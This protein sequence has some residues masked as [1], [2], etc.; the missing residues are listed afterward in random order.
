MTTKQMTYAAAATILD[1]LLS[2]ALSV[3]TLTYPE[4]PA[5]E[6]PRPAPS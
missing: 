5:S 1:P 6:T 4:G 3:A 2:Q